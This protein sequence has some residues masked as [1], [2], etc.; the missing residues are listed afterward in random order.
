M[1]VIE[2]GL[3]VVAGSDVSL[4]ADLGLLPHPVPQIVELGSADVTATHYLD[5]LENR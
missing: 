5:A 2:S 1:V 3:G 4:F